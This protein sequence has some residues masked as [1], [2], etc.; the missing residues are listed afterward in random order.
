M[1]RNIPVRYTQD[2]FSWVDLST[3]EICVF[4]ESKA[5]AILL[6]ADGSCQEMLLKEW[7][8]RGTYDFL[9]L[10]FVFSAAVASLAVPFGINVL[11]GKCCEPEVLANMY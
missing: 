5:P 2:L 3:K 1:V 4:C 6:R 9:C 11:L 8:N 10:A 7:P